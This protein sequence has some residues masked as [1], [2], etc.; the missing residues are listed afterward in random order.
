M[1]RISDGRPNVL[2]LIDEK[3]LAWIVNTPTPGAK[4]AKDEAK[5]RSTCILRGIPITT[6]IDALEATIEGLEDMKGGFGDGKFR[7]EVCS[8][9]E[10]QRHAPKVNV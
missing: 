1:F 6:T 5:I 10:Y 2:D 3:D 8:I 9:Q 4:A 7:V